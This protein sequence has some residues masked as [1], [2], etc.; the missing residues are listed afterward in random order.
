VSPAVTT[1]SAGT[2][3]VAASRVRRASIWRR[4]TVLAVSIFSL[5]F[6]ATSV[7]MLI[8]VD[9]VQG[10]L[11]HSVRRT[12]DLRTI[13]S[14]AYELNDVVKDSARSE[15]VA[16]HLA[17]IDRLAAEIERYRLLDR[18]PEAA[19]ERVGAAAQSLAVLRTAT[20]EG[21]DSAMLV[22]PAF[23][24]LDDLAAARD[25][26]RR[27]TAEVSVD[28]YSAWSFMNHLLI[29]ACV[30][31]GL[32][33]V[34][35]FIAIRQADARHILE[36]EMEHAFERSSEGVAL[37]DDQG[38]IQRVNEGF[39]MLFGD[40][41]ATLVGTAIAKCFGPRSEAASVEFRAIVESGA[42]EGHFEVE[43]PAADGS[44]RI[45]TC[46][47]RAMTPLRGAAQLWALRADD[48]TEQRRGFAAISERADWFAA[49][50]TAS[51][52]GMALIEPSGRIAYTNRSFAD[53]TGTDAAM[54]TGMAGCDFVAQISSRS[55]EA[56]HGFRRLLGERDDGLRGS[57]LPFRVMLHTPRLRVLLLSAVP[58]VGRGGRWLGRLA[59]VRDVTRDD[60]ARQAKD[61]F[62]GN[63]SH[64]LRT[65]LTSISGFVEILRAEKIG[66]VNERQ[67]EALRVV[68]ENVSR[69]SALVGDLL[70]VG[71]IEE[72]RLEWGS[73]DLGKLVTEVVALERLAAEAKGIRCEVIVTGDCRID[74]DEKRLRQLVSNLISNAIKYT[75]EGSVSARV[76]EGEG[77]IRT[78]EVADTGI[79]IDEADRARIFDRFFRADNADTKAIRGTGLG[80]AIAKLVVEQHGGRIDVESA[81]GKGSKFTVMLPSERGGRIPLPVGEQAPARRAQPLVLAID[82]D[83]LAHR[84]ITAA[85]RIC[86]MD[87]VCAETGDRGIQLAAEHRPDVVL[88]DIE[89]P[90]ING[91]EVVSRLRRELKMTHVPIVV[92]S[93]RE[94]PPSLVQ[95][96]VTAY[97]QK[98]VRS[99]RLREAVL[100][101]IGEES[102]GYGVAAE[103]ES[104]VL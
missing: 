21:R 15:P 2:D 3:S 24:V 9:D 73:V 38:I 94:A 63:V 47:V 46:H 54:L 89:L 96:G 23:E 56:T 95:L 61:A 41:T 28:L 57:I 7:F 90:D 79:G 14:L 58:V 100:R 13:E 26:L 92:I 10:A 35:M 30:I 75:F 65:P 51:R 78:I 19:R 104:G 32:L 52:D 42:Q 85:L 67:R 82:D 64:E 59:M 34:A 60:K 68:S 62:L 83:I 45:V 93:G 70:A 87:V 27:A 91:F 71:E 84:I 4:V 25:A 98:P 17:V 40:A 8:H 99:E 66:S 29:A 103:D 22:E 88:V 16:A 74:G 44:N 102:R 43:L 76:A 5:A 6:I 20:I 39:R 69:L 33:G 97:L 12:T 55:A 86:G 53:L 72:E 50:L 101:A 37:C 36:L 48:V 81:R 77:G 11:A 18:V 49:M 80:L 31:T 1:P